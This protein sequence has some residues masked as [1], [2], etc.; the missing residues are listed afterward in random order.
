MRR[1][2]EELS[3]SP[4]TVSN[5]Y[6]RPDQLSE[7]LRQRVFETAER[8]GYAGPDP[9]ARSLRRQ[10]T[11]LVGVLY[12]NALSYA[13][14]DAAQILFLK[15]FA[16]AAE[17]AG[18]GLVLV[19]GSVGTSPEERAS[20]AADAAV[21]G[22]VVYSIAENDPLIEAALRRRLPMVV[23]DQPLQDSIPFV[24]I[25][26]EAAAREVTQHLLNL[27]HENF[28]VVSFTI[29]E[30]GLYDG[31]ADP[32]RQ[33]SSTF[34]VTR[35][36]LTGYR[37]ILEDA[38]LC[39]DEVP[40]HECP[41]SSKALG[42]EAAGILLCRK[43]RPTAILTLSDQLALGVIETAKECGL[44]VPEDLSVVGFD[45]IP[46][47]K[48]S[49]PPLTTIHQD[50]AEKGEVAGRLLV[51]QLREEK[52]RVENLLPFELIVRGSTNQSS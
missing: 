21:D 16:A 12:S 40:V 28:G 11:N 2:A 50:H 36:R 10:K 44:S 3:V 49:T 51:A 46:E 48:V 52:V 26:D 19:P 38:G 41:G 27:G 39:W 18:M 15:G 23:V 9:V 29:S 13:F 7:S 45:D 17:E 42:Q 33:A 5:A 47:A 20:A 1:V 25:D 6:N 43:P 24:G 22:F 8:L 30:T 31:L 32:S 35:A 4:M 14:D 34:P 37:A